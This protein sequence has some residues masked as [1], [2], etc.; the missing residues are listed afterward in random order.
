MA[1][2]ADG[3]TH[4]LVVQDAS[5]NPVLVPATVAEGTQHMVAVQEEVVTV[6]DQQVRRIW[7]P[8]K[9]VRVPKL[10]CAAL[11]SSTSPS[12]R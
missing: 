7:G 3:T 10:C 4:H 12:W 2:S 9:P 6:A 8:L 1:T 5:G 11:H